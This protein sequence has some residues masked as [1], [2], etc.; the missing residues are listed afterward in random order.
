M[1]ISWEIKG[2]HQYENLYKSGIVENKHFHRTY[3]LI[4]NLTYNTQYLE[5]I[6]NGLGQKIHATI[7]TEL[8]KTF[9]ITGM[10]IVESILYYFIK[11][12]GMQKTVDF[13]EIAT[14]G[15][16]E[17][18]VQGKTLKV[19]TKIFQKIDTP[20]EIE[21]T[22]DS[23]LKKTEKKKLF[24]DDHSIYA[25]LN[26]LRKLRNKIHLY[27]IEEN[28]DHDWNNF[29]EKELRM[30]KKSLRKILFSDRFKDGSDLK[31]QL[32]DFLG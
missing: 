17:K 20:L 21:M 23:M 26:R 19:E 25:E 22:L 11:S 9:V 12:E 18:V 10:S 4:K 13:E 24:G 1:E 28:L 15:S 2:A 27:Y 29:N 6:N 32:L 7:K 31:E 14:M 16:N 3:E 8:I 5:F 30:M